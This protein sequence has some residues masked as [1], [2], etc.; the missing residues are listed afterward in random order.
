SWQN[1][2]AFLDCLL[3]TPPPIAVWHGHRFDLLREGYLL[4]ERIANAKNL[5]Q[6]C[7]CLQTLPEPQRPLLMRQALFELG[8]QVRKLHERGWAH[9]DLKATNILVQSDSFIRFWFIDLV[10]AWRPW[11]LS[12]SRRQKDVARLH[13]SFCFSNHLSRTD[14]LRFLRAYL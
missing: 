8:R 11:R 14:R 10:G 7:E 6:F 5:H 2:H 12:D 13:A 3:P 1:G 4:T 9:R